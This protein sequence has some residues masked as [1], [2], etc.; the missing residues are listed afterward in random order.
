[1]EGPTPSLCRYE[2]INGKPAWQTTQVHLW[3]I[4]LAGGDGRRLQ[5]FIRT[6]FG[7]ERPKQ[8]CAFLDHRLLLRHTLVRAERL[9]PPER[10]LTII[11][12]DISPMPE[13]SF[14]TSRLGVLPVH[15]VYWSDWGDPA[16]IL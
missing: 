7:S 9:I 14:T 5:P 15:G 11:T 2:A 3:G 10:L 8:Y 13:R 12:S 4:V 16:R 6:C 1:M